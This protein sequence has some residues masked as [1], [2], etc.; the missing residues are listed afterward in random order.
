MS[1]IEVEAA[2]EAALI[3][4]GWRIKHREPWPRPEMRREGEAADGTMWYAS[5]PA[6]GTQ[7]TTQFHFPD[8]VLE[9]VDVEWIA[10]YAV[11]GVELEYDQLVREGV[12]A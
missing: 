9:D 2:I 5:K 8:A 3:A 7:I 6:L 4:K 12:P 11:R 10:E 1:R